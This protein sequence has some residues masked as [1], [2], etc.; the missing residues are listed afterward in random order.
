MVS[1]ILYTLI[2]LG[3]LIFVHEL[4]HFLVA[5]K[6]GIR[7]ER[8]SLGL[9]PKIF[10]FQHGET[11]YCLSWIPFGGYVKVAGMADIGS[12][13]AR[14]EPW[15]FPSKSIPVRMAV[16][17]A[18]PFMNFAFAFLVLLVLYWGYGV[19]T[20]ESTAVS[21]LENS[22]SQRAGVEEGDQILTVNGRPV[23]N[24]YELMRALEATNYQ[25]ATFEVDRRGDLHALE[26]PASDE[27][28]Y[29]LAVLPST[30]VGRVV[31]DMPAA[32]AGLQNGDRIL[33]VAGESVTNWDEMSAAIRRYPEQSISLVWERDGRSIEA[34][35]VPAARQV[36]DETIGQIGIGPHTGHASVGLAQAVGMSGERVWLVSWL[37]LDFIGEILQGE[38]STDELGG[39]LRIAQMA[40]E[41]ADQGLKYFLS[42]LAMIS[43]NLAVINLLPIPV[44]DGGHLT[45][46]TLEAIM[47]RPLSLRQRERFQQVGLVLMLFLMVLVTFNDV[48]QM[49]V[50]HIMQ[51]F[52]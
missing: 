46:L 34:Q 51:L 19:E 22:V 10:G 31:G 6:G 33:Q 3:V 41:T 12:E 32:A 39:P 21:P 16:I 37:I 5:K 27:E 11:E 7:V 35:I 14:G 24:S 40:G 44:L 36:E 52:D 42:F 1:T 29:G 47:R 4:G 13:T 23:S 17:A 2:A 49:F 30:R 9:G 50:P 28:G 25:G 38:R 8:F 15:E 26:L 48:T 18:G 20:W 43:I 45:F